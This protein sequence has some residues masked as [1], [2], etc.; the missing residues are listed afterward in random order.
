[1]IPALQATGYVLCARHRAHKKSSPP[2]KK[3]P[4]NIKKTLDKL[5]LPCYNTKAV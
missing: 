2:A 5:L 3:I 4:K 1:M